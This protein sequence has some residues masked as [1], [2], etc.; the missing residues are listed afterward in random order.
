MNAPNPI[1]PPS[2]MGP[3]HPVVREAARIVLRTIFFYLLLL[4]VLLLWRG[5]GLFIYEGF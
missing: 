1:S 3:K 5:T 4:A 2:P